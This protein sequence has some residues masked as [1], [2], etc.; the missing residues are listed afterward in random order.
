[1]GV[2]VIPLAPSGFLG[3]SP[4]LRACVIL[5]LVWILI[6]LV[7]V[8]LFGAYSVASLRITSP[9]IF[10]RSTGPTHDPRHIVLRLV[11]CNQLGSACC[12]SQPTRAR[13]RLR[14]V[15]TR[16][17]N[18]V[19]SGQHPVVYFFMLSSHSYFVCSRRAA[20]PALSPQSWS[21]PHDDWTSWFLFFIIFFL[22]TR[23]SA[24]GPISQVRSR[25]NKPAWPN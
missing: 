10:A 21:S 20:S 18:T 4:V 24:L 11:A 5:H 1:L 13:E 14:L 3:T 19:C 25:P 8:V 6:S 7:S 15:H 12:S 22:V 9:F 17:V 16:R 23:P 2:R